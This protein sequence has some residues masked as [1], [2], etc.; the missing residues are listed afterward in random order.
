MIE[1]ILELV[2]EFFGELILE[3]IAALFID[4][5]GH[6]VKK[7]AGRSKPV[8]PMLA[9]CGYVAAGWLAGM[10]SLWLVPQVFVKGHWLQIAGLLLVPIAAGSVMSL[11]GSWRKQH[12]KD[13]IRIETFAYGFCFAFT[14]ALVRFIWGIPG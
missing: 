10:L 4:A 5:S 9:A 6:G 12:D 11:I 14:M 1:F 2:F 13:V 7:V 8:D 3:L